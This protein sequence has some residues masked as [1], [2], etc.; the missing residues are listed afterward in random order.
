M[1]EPTPTTYSA[2]PDETLIARAIEALPETGDRHHTI[3]QLEHQTVCLTVAKAPARD[4]AWVWFS[5][6]AAERADLTSD[7]LLPLVSA[8]NFDRWYYVAHDIG[9]ATPLSEFRRVAELSTARSLALLL[10]IAHALDD[11]VSQGKPPYEVTPDSVFLDPRLGAMVGDLGVARE[12]LGN[13]ADDPH[14]PWVAPEVLRGEDA[15]PRSAVYAFGAIAYTLLT[16]K[17]PH[18]GDAHDIAAAAPPRLSEARPDLPATLDTVFA[19]SMA[20]DPRKRYATAAEARHLLNLIIYGAPSVPVLEAQ[21]RFRRGSQATKPA[22]TQQHAPRLQTAVEEHPKRGPA[23]VALLCG[24]ALLAGALA[25]IVAGGG[26]DAPAPHPR[27]DAA[28]M[29][30]ELP[31]GW[32]QRPAEAGRLEAVATRDGDATL[33]AV[34]SKGRVGDADQGTPVVLG[35]YEAWSHEPSKTEDGGRTAAFVIPTESG[36]VE[37]TCAAGPSSATN[38]LALCERTASTLQL[39]VQKAVSLN[40]VRQAAQRWRAAATRLQDERTAGRARLARAAQQSGQ[41]QSAEALAGIYENAA[42]RFAALTGGQPVVRAARET[43]S[44]YR[45]LARAAQGNSSSAWA[46]ARAE[47]RDTESQLN[48]TLAAD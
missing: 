31:D 4:D 37:I 11:A 15:H 13:P 45:A 23:L 25:G 35:D 12:A 2:T 21:P 44:A 17:A 24:G 36:K 48:R 7:R 1:Y 9:N 38:T 16:G 42:R 14:A 27:V 47:V 5:S 30:V 10:G 43:A 22:P 39:G 6:A 34:S 41:I 26:D 40:A 46:S 8:G 20:Q 19:V 18:S 28:G 29:S 3:V 32:Q 33:T